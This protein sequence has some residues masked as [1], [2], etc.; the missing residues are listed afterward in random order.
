MTASKSEDEVA[1]FD[2]DFDFDAAY[3][4]LMAGG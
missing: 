1:I 4:A 2:D 3:D